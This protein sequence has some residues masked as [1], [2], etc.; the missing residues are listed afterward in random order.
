MTEPPDDDLGVARAEEQTGE[1][2][3]HHGADG[4]R[5]DRRHGQAHAEQCSEQS[6]TA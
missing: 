1:I 2:G 6:I 3:R 4:K 5:L